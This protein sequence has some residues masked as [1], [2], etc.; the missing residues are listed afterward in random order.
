MTEIKDCRVCG[1][2]NLEQVIDL[3]SQPWC[4]NFLKEEELGKEPFYP[5]RV[6][7]CN[8][9]STSQLDFTVKKE[10]MFGEH[11]YLSGVTKSLSKHFQEIANDINKKINVDVTTKTILDIGSNDGTQLKHFKN[12]G[13]RVLGVESSER[14]SKIAKENNIETL[15][16]FFNLETMKQI[17]EKFDVINA[18]GVFFHLEELHSATEAVK[19]GLKKNGV[20]VVQ[21]LYMKSIMENNAFDQIYH[22]HLLYYTIKTISNLLARYELEIF[23]AYLA[24]IHGGQMIAHVTH[25]GVKIKSDRLKK[26]IQEE[27]RSLCNNKKS[28]EDF[29][30]RIKRMKV[31][32]IDY[33]EEKKSKGN[34]IYGMGAP[35][36]GNTM[37]NFFNIGTNYIDCLLEKNNLRENLYSPGKHI[38]ILMESKDTLIADVY[39]VLAWNFK[40]EILKN[41]RNLLE[42]GKEFYFPVNPAI[43]A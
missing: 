25:K 16:Q 5:L 38:P 8:E 2:K 24:P 23:D 12:L 6:L 20:F 26:I 37:L 36:K 13:W 14:I 4:N 15:N 34:V 22:E 43:S 21:F 35:V 7:F 1:S 33:L 40:K 30:K 11:T 41:N 32:N 28:Y 10:I 9:C 31:E 3:G 29:Y 27:E 42:A 17:N 39:Y 18:A 19:L